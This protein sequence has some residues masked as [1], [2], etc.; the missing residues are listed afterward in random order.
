MTTMPL[1][2]SGKSKYLLGIIS[3][4][5]GHVSR[6]VLK[7]LDN[8]DLIVHAGD[9]DTP[10]VLPVLKARAPVVAVRGNMDMMKWAG[11]LKRVETIRV[12]QTRILVQHDIEAINKN[13]PVA[14][15][16]I[17][18]IVSGHT[19]RPHLIDRNGITL[20]NPGSA[21]FPRSPLSASMAIMQI[22]K[23]GIEVHFIDLETGHYSPWP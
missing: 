11:H 20:V 12:N 10:E 5:H 3:D 18:V 4:T 2:L 13:I 23:E 19:H 14:A 22:G 6:S 9:I 7:H 8:V 17:D 1:E 15:T 16:N 21:T